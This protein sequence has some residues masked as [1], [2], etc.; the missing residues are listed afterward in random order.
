MNDDQITN[1]YAS[2]DI[3]ELMIAEKIYA[4]FMFIILMNWDD[5]ASCNFALVNTMAIE[6]VWAVQISTKHQQLWYWPITHGIS[7]PESKNV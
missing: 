5:T 2:L 7:Q 6:D 1:A 4:T 3:N